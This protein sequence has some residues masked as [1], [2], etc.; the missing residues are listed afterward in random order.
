M[1]PCILNTGLTVTGHK[2]LEMVP[3]KPLLE[4]VDVVLVI[5]HIKNACHAGTSVPCALLYRSTTHF[6]NSGLSM[7][8]VPNLGTTVERPRRCTVRIDSWSQPRKR[9][10]RYGKCRDI[11]WM[12]LGA[13]A[14]GSRDGREKQ[15]PESI[16]TVSSWYVWPLLHS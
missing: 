7:E 15:W 1:F 4:H 16:S 11:A 14:L 10:H 13:D 12:R 6:P 2:D 9:C 8:P 3:L 5:L